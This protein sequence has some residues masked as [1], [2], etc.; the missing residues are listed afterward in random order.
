MGCT[1]PGLT[2][3]PGF[4]DFTLPYAEQDGKVVRVPFF[5]KDAIG[6]AGSL[7]SNVSD[8]AK[9]L[10]LHLNGGKHAMPGLVSK[11]NLA[12]MHS[13]QM[14]IRDVGQLG[15]SDRMDSFEEI[16]SGSYGLGWRINTYRGS[17]MIHHAGGIDGFSALV[18]FLPDEDAGVVVLSNLN[19]SPLPYLI[20]FAIYDHMLNLN[21]IDWDRR[22]KEMVSAQ[23]KAAEQSQALWAANRRAGS[24]PSHCSL[25]DYTGDFEHPAYGAYTVILQDGHLLACYSDQAFPLNHYHYDVF[26]LTLG[27][28]GMTLPV[29]FFGDVKGC[30][31]HLSIPLEPAVRDIVFTRKIRD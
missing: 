15:S 28:D 21:P 20:T 9:W 11:E 31:S 26:E 2:N 8:L 23:K 6:P 4:T 1:S 10:F 19:G 29:S 24:R 13:P 18:S 17:N 30:I 14:V 16:G 5:A 25:E 12:Q 27:L 22:L 3:A 7:C